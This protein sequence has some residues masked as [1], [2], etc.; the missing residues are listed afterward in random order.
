M[1]RAHGIYYSRRK[2]IVMAVW[3]GVPVVAGVARDV[4]RDAQAFGAFRELAFR[5]VFKTIAVPVELI[6]DW[7]CS[8]A[9]F[10]PALAWQGAN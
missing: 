9:K 10:L 7:S 6:L 1:R 2:H 3:D 5:S 8:K 4:C